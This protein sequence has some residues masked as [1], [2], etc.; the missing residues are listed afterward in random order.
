MR[1]N[2]NYALID[3]EMVPW[4]GSLGLTLNQAIQ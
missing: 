1:L 4:P 2:L 3:E